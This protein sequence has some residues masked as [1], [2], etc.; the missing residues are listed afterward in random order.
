MEVQE[1]GWFLKS[2]SKSGPR[3]ADPERMGL[4]SCW[5]KDLRTK[6]LDFLSEKLGKNQRGD[7]AKFSKL[8]KAGAAVTH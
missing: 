2:H 6:C 7:L 5:E 8:L 4:E 3:R 1:G